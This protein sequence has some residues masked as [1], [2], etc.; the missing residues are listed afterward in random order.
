MRLKQA[1]LKAT[2][3][4]QKPA[5]DALHRRIWDQVVYVPGG[6]FDAPFAW[7]KTLDGVAPMAMPVFWNITK[8]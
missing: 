6:Q 1:Y 7:R 8:K 2:G 5:L 3:D 4:A